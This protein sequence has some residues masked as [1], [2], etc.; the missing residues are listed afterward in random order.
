MKTKQ[1]TVRI[2]D[3]VEEILNRYGDQVSTQLREDLKT[4]ISILRSGILHLRRNTPFALSDYRFLCE[5]LREFRLDP[6]VAGSP[7][8][9]SHIAEALER[10]IFDS[11]SGE[12]NF[13]Y[14]ELIKERLKKLSSRESLGLIHMIRVYWNFMEENPGEDQEKALENF[15]G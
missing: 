8:L 6:N 5:Y 10:F 11:Q 13:E 3:E 12:F 4:L 2:G 1:I 14:V 15:F 9:G 7:T